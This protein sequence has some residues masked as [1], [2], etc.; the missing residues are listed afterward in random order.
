MLKGELKLAYRGEY[1]V[2]S[3]NEQIN[4]LREA[5]PT[6]YNEDEPLYDIDNAWWYVSSPVGPVW[7][8]ENGETI[9]QYPA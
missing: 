5:W 7:V 9:W 8:Y 6:Y 2:G 3:V 4:L 1:L